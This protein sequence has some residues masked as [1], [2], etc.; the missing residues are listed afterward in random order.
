MVLG[1]GAL[2][3]GKKKGLFDN[4][5]ETLTQEPLLTDEQKK[6]MG[7]LAGFGESGK[8]GD[9]QAGQAYGGSLGDFDLRGLE[10]LG[11]GKIGDVLNAGRPQALGAAESALTSLA[12]AQFNPDDPSSGFGAFSRQVARA[13][14]NANDVLNREAAITGDRY[15]TSIGGQKK[16]LA[17]QQS[18]ALLSQLANLYNT[19]QDRKLSASNSLVGLAGAEQGIN[20][21]QIGDAFNFGGIERALKNSE[22]QAKL[23]E[24]NRQ[25]NERLSSIGALETVFG[26]NVPY[27]MKEISVPQPNPFSQLLNVGLTAGGFALGG[28]AGG[29]AGSSL[30]GLFSGGSGGIGSS[31]SF[32]PFAS[33]SSGATNSLQRNLGY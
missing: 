12:N 11:L 19:A 21:Q 15:S 18:D 9:F 1:I 28:P 33:A 10:A 2:A 26:K 5:E 31:T 22:A 17:L 7:L 13:T 30:G 24:F 8:L 32:N 6:A 23:N 20:S 14:Q 4:K 25:R 27:G 16:D 29:A 3:L